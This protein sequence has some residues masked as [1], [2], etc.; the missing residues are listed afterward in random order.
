[1][2]ILFSGDFHANAAGELGV[3]T[4]KSL[5]KIFCMIGLGRASYDNINLHKALAKKSNL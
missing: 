3:I 2:S 4:K 5:L 1:M